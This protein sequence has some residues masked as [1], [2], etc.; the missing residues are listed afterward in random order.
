[1]TDRCNWCGRFKAKFCILCEG[2]QTTIEGDPIDNAH[3][4]VSVDDDKY[5]CNRCR[6]RTRCTIRRPEKANI[7]GWEDRLKCEY[8]E[9]DER[10]W[11]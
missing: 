10:W 3:P 9:E 1:M 5:K 4:R 8:F 6:K 7:C 2:T 11:Q